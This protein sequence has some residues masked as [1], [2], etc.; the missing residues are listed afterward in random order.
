MDNQEAKSSRAW[1]EG[2]RHTA[3]ALDRIKIEELR[4]LT[5]EQ[6]GRIF[7]D[8]AFD[9]DT[10]WISPERRDSTGLVEQQRLFMR[11]DEHPTRHRRRP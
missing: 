8:T 10:L 9:P 3:V 4:G 2:W 5:Q 1:V 6:A 7:A 11:S